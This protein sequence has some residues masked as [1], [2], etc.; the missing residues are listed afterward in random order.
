M[1]HQSLR[2]LKKINRHFHHNGNGFFMEAVFLSPE[3]HAP[4]AGGRKSMEI[5]PKFNCL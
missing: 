4:E 5:N 1:A 2:L 3:P